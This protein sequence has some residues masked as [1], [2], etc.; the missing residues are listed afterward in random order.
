[1]ELTVC[2]PCFGR[3]ER[4][5][6]LIQQVAEQTIGNWE[7]YFIGDCCPDFQQILDSGYFDQVRK[8]IKQENCALIT[9]NMPNHSGGWGYAI[10]N[11]IKELASG[12]YFIYLDNDDCIENNHFESYLS[13]INGTDYDFVYFNSITKFNGSWRNT[14]LEYGLIGHSELIIRT[15]FLKTMP[16]HT[17]AYGH[18]WTLISNMINAGARYVKSLKKPTYIVMG[19][20]NQRETNID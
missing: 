16:P 8:S 10:R 7:A 6:R 17:E 9:S 12:K 1:M 19:A 3:P 20:G 15:N 5:K 4:T 13:A 14:S 18:D 2:V 11:K